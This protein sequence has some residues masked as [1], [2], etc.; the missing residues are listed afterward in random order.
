M[1]PPFFG[2]ECWW[3]AVHERH[4]AHVAE[5]LVGAVEQE[6]VHELGGSYWRRVRVDHDAAVLLLSSGVC[7]DLRVELRELDEPK[8]GLGDVV[9]RAEDIDLGCDVDRAGLSF[10]PG[11]S[12]R[13]D[14]LGVLAQ[15]QEG[16]IDARVD[17]A[18]GRRVG[19]VQ[20]HRGSLGQ[21]RNRSHFVL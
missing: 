14:G 4:H 3:S 17:L 11:A 12:L 1:R 5:E 10:R 13:D 21:Y 6:R 16:I 15:R 19:L 20:G 9:G 2:E 18:R 8:V 7:R